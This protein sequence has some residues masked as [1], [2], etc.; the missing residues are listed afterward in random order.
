LPFFFRVV[1]RKNIMASDYAQILNV[2]NRAGLHSPFGLLS[3]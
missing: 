2:G 1:K 3:N